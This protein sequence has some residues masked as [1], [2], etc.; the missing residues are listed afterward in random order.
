[1]A[2]G[3]FQPRRLLDR[4][5]GPGFDVLCVVPAHGELRSCYGAVP[6][7]MVSTLMLEP[8]SVLPQFPLQ[9]AV[10]YGTINSFIYLYLSFVISL[11]YVLTRMSSIF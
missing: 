3:L 5:E 6:Y 1:M 2:R 8:A 11:Y 10:L 9:L 7:L 4:F